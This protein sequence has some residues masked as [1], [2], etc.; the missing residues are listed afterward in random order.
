MSI[1]YAKGTMSVAW[2]A[3]RTTLKRGQA[4]DGDADLVRE[5]PDLFAAEPERP[6]GRPAGRVERATRA[7]GEVRTPGGFRKGSRRPE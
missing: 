1:V 4:W 3:G 6:A 2:S 7:P 5:R